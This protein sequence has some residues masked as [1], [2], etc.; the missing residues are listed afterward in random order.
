[1]MALMSA[2]GAV[3]CPYIYFN[4]TDSKREELEEAKKKTKDEIYF[5]I[6]QIKKNKYS[7]LKLKQSRESVEK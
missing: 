6:E 1:M 2:Y 7:I 3:W 4:R 5:I